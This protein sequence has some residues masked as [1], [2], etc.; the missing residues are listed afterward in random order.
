MSESGRLIVISGPS[1]V[2]K[3]TILKRVIAET[4]AVFSVSATT[5]SP[6]DGERDGEHYLF[7]DEPTFR[8]MIASDELLEWAEVFDRLY[9]T[10]AGPVNQAMIEGK[11]VLMDVDVQGGRQ[12]HGHMP[13]ATFVLIVPPDGDVL[14]ARLEH[15]GS[16]TEDELK[17]RLSKA[18]AEIDAAKLSGVYN[19]M[20]VNDDLDR[21]V[22]ELVEIVAS[23]TQE[24]RKT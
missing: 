11:T 22:K 17:Q 10:P 12:V 8:R 24:N 5:R 1:G 23:N 14:A 16:E 21:A 4:D 20:I 15:R 7:L 13:D 6:R 3:S 2:G 18:Q 19:H 9:G